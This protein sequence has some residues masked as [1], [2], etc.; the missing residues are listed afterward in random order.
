MKSRELVL[1]AFRHRSNSSIPFD[2]GSTGV[3]GIHV[4]AVEALRRHYGLTPGPVKVT[5]PYQMLGEVD[6]ELASVIGLDVTGIFGRCD[7]FGIP[8]DEGWKEFRSF[9]GQTL[10][11]PEKFVTSYD[12]DGSLLIYPGGACSRV[13]FRRNNKTGT[14]R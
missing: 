2:I 1:E 13:F 11:V 10:L 6:D 4:K 9:W 8:H 12:S 14:Y 7:M 3:T 5:E